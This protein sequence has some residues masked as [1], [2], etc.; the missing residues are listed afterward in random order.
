MK[1]LEKLVGVPLSC[2][3]RYVGGYFLGQ[4]HYR[5]DNGVHQVTQIHPVVLAYLAGMKDGPASPKTEKEMRWVKKLY[6]LNLVYL[7]RG[8][9]YWIT[10]KGKEA[11]Y[12]LFPFE[13]G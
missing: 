4:V 2:V 5:D 9:E 13:I 1:P 10:R 7:V 11:Q 12:D 3:P 6:D 8:N